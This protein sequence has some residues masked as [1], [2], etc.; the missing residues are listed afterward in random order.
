MMPVLDLRV[1]SA[2][3]VDLNSPEDAL[4][5]LDRFQAG[6]PQRVHTIHEAFAAMDPEQTAAAM[7]SLHTHALSVGA[8]QLHAITVHA[9]ATVDGDLLR[10]GSAPTITSNRRFLRDLTTEASLFTQ[11]Y[12]ALRSNPTLLDPPRTNPPSKIPSSESGPD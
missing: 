2:L 3:A 4:G 10:T 8:L 6:L 1:V 7:T 9:Q 11:A 12:L 5:F